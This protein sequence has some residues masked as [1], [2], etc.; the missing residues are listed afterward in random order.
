MLRGNTQTVLA[1][2]NRE[3][4]EGAMANLAT[5]PTDHGSKIQHPL[6]FHHPESED[7]E[8]LTAAFSMCVPVV[9]CLLCSFIYKAN[10]EKK[11]QQH[12]EC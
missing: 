9:S 11:A 7:R 8:H 3:C 10:R 12:N 6:F 5:S 4:F 2:G 1:S